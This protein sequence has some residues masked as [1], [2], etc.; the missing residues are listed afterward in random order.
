MGEVR[1]GGRNT[2]VWPR[3]P[4]EAGTFRE[5]PG[6]RASVGAQLRD[7]ALGV[8]EATEVPQRAMWGNEGEGKEIAVYRR[9]NPRADFQLVPPL[10]SLTPKGRANTCK[11]GAKEGKVGEGGA[12]PQGNE[13]LWP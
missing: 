6:Q 1:W 5:A 3:A 8:D 7:Q 9:Q 10:L 2:S 12:R 11:F 4:A 13:D